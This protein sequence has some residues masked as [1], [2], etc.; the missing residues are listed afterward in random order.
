MSEAV[1]KGC[2]KHPDQSGSKVKNWFSLKNMQTN[3]GTNLRKNPIQ[4]IAI[5]ISVDINLIIYLLTDGVTHIIISSNRLN[6][7]LY[8]IW[9]GIVRHNGD[10]RDDL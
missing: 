1:T 7:H 6:L 4:T 8:T 3:P 10:L 5:S 2:L 9:R